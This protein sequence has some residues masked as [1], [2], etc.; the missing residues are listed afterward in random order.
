MKDGLCRVEEHWT[1]DE[2][3][4]VVRLNGVANSFGLEEY[5]P[6]SAEAAVVCQETYDLSCYVLSS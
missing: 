5:V 1:D 4:L 2:Q 3:R 6:R